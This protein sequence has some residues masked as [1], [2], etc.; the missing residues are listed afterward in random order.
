MNRDMK[1][2]LTIL[3]LAAAAIGA[4]V[5]AVLLVVKFKEQ[6]GDFF[7]E[8]KMRCPCCHRE[9]DDYADD[10]LNCLCDIDEI[11]E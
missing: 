11:T 1:N 10:E 3:A 5:T 9:E 7:A 2:I 4:V 6:I 8:M